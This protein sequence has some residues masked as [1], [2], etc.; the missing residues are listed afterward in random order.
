MLCPY[1]RGAEIRNLRVLYS[2]TCDLFS[3]LL[4]RVQVR[5]L[6]FRPALR[7]PRSECEGVSS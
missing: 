4:P 3:P 6:Y 5:I 1:E 2:R 7:D